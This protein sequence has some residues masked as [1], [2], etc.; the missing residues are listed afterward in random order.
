LWI[1]EGAA[2]VDLHKFAGITYEDRVSAFLEQYLR[3]H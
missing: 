1:V 2:H 3:P